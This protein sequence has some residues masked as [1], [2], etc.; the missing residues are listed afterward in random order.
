MQVFVIKCRC[1]YKESIDKG[2]CNKGFIFNPSNCKCECDKLCDVGEYLDYENCKCRKKLVDK[3][4]EEYSENIDE[5]EMIYNETLNDYENVCNSCTTY[6]VLFFIAVLIITE[7]GS[8]YCYF[9]WYLKRI[10][11]V[12][13]LIPI[14]KQQ[15]IKHINEKYQTN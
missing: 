13:I 7:I 4:V 6:I 8:A 9:Y 10:L 5:N 11:L 2:L 3:L 15:F 1:K 12:L 14:L